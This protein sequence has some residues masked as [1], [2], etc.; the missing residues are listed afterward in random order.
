MKKCLFC[1][2]YLS[3][4]NRSM[5]HVV[6]RW[7]ISHL[8]AQDERFIG[9]NWSYPNEPII[10]FS[11][12]AHDFLS[13][14]LGNVCK[15]CNTGWMAQLEEDTRPLL[16]VLMT[17]H[18]T[19]LTDKQCNIL[20]R[21]TFKTASA[22]NYSVNFKKIIPLEHILEFF[23]DSRL[24]N[25]ATVDFAWCYTERIHWFVGGN[26]KFALLSRKIT[27]S[28]K[29]ASYVITLQFGHV[30]LRL[31]WVP[32]DGIKAFNNPTNA[33]YRIFPQST[34]ELKVIRGPIF[35]DDSQFHF[36]ATVLAQEGVY[37]SNLDFHF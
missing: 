25:N 30:L 33:V 22:L 9:K 24:P 27:N 21:W 6:P 17:G 20:A 19:T 12:R 8:E 13:L 1:S 14:V 34:S 7:L 32:V 37:P 23:I 28:H 11:E 10:T 36:M 35:K 18:S 5:E 15:A 3:R 29:K 26:K 4:Q 31:A 16:Q 2:T